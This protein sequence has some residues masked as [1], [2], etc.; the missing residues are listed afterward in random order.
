[1]TLQLVAQ[2]QGVVLPQIPHLYQIIQTTG[3]YEI[4]GARLLLVEVK[5]ILLLGLRARVIRIRICGVAAPSAGPQRIVV[6]IFLL[7]QQRELAEGW[8]L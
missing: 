1:M 3:D 7:V 8:R 6:G 5:G 4:L 2:L